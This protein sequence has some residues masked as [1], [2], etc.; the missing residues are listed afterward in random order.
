M[1]LHD[2]L[3]TTASYNKSLVVFYYSLDVT[4]NRFIVEKNQPIIYQDK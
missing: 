4:Q 1:A 2:F 3:M